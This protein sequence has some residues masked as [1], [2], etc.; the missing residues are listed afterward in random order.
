MASEAL[1]NVR[2]EIQPYPLNNKKV[3]N[4]W[5]AILSKLGKSYPRTKS[6]NSPNYFT[7]GT[8]VDAIAFISD[9]WKIQLKD[10]NFTITTSIRFHTSYL[11]D[12]IDEKWIDIDSNSLFY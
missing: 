12:D 4:E 5:L 2:L 10:H 11:W 8:E 1:Y 9:C 3:E 7:F 6:S